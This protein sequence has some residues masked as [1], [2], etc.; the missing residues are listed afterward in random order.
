[1]TL[2]LLETLKN[3]NLMNHSKTFQYTKEYHKSQF[4]VFSV[5]ILR[6]VRKFTKTNQLYQLINTI[7][8]TTYQSITNK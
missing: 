7:K 2:H 8:Q 4:E 1:M 6:I 5:K 3:L